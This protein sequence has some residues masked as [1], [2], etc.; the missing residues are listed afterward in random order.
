MILVLDEEISQSIAVI[1]TAVTGGGKAAHNVLYDGL[2]GLFDRFS[3]LSADSI[4][5]RSGVFST[6]ASRLLFRD[7]EGLLETARIKRADAANSFAAACAKGQADFRQEWKDTLGEWNAAERS[8]QVKRIL[9]K[10]AIKI[11]TMTAPLA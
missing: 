4:K 6:L 10:V 3:A 2:K 9:E 5:D 1:E 11:Q 8:G 7:M